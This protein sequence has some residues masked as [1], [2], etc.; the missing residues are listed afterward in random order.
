MKV[1]KVLILSGAALLVFFLVSQPEGA[2][3]IV[4]SILQTLQEA[5][6]A[7]IT[8]VRSVFNG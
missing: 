6:E 5:A 7:L 4:N 3:S 8:F 2:A 1:K